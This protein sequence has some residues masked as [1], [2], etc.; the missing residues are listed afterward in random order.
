M[1]KI[2]HKQLKKILELVSIFEQGIADI[3]SA[4]DAQERA[5][6][7]AMQELS[8]RQLSS[9]LSSLDVDTVNR[10][11]LGIRVS[12]LRDAGI[13]DM[14]KLCAMSYKELT[15]IKGIGEESAYLI[16]KV[17]GKIKQELGA[18]VRVRI[19]PENRDDATGRLLLAVKS[20]MDEQRYVK[21]AQAL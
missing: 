13:T 3:A 15:R 19:E 1:S 21:E 7:L 11:K 20:A 9:L 5:A 16:Y 14:E 17:A 12:A 4:G 10:D 2:D 8:Q 6:A 18:D